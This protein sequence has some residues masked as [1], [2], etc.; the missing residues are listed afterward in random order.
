[1]RAPLRWAIAAS[2]LL[3][4]TLA[5]SLLLRPARSDW[6]E[7]APG[8]AHFH[9][10]VRFD[11]RA[12]F[13]ALAIKVDLRHPDIEPF[14]RMPRREVRPDDAHF[15]LSWPDI[16]LE[17]HQLRV[18][19]S[20]TPFNAKPDRSLVAEKEIEFGT[21]GE[22]SSFP[23]I[24]GWPGRRVYSTEPVIAGGIVTHVPATSALLLIDEDKQITVARDPARSLEILRRVRA[25]GTSSPAWGFGY[26]VMQIWDGEI[27][28]VFTSP[29]F[30][31]DRLNYRPFVGA[32]GERRHLYLMAFE[33]ASTLDMLEFA[34][35]TGVDAGGQLDAGNTT[36]LLL[37]HGLDGI[38][39]HSGIRGG[40]PIA[41]YLGI[42]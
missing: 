37:G 9:G 33:H 25:A 38:V 12:P 22:R 41:A 24:R 36:W 29:P 31:D 1:M 30:R 34:R 6:R 40:R 28:E 15:R 32:D 21:R 19:I 27:S 3:A 39:P 4:T 2:L 7:L 14:A 11:G 20:T 17:R 10:E 35:I 42:R 13:M 8:V 16:E 26:E 5:L 18:L 23:G